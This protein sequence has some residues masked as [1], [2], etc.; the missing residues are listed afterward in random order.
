LY[1]AEYSSTSHFVGI[2]DIKKAILLEG[3][4][5]ASIAID[6][7]FT[8]YHGGIYRSSLKPPIEAGNHAVEIIGWGK[9]NNEEYWIILNQYGRF[10]GENGRIRIKM[11]TNE[12]LIESF[13]YGALPVLDGHLNESSA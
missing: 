8:I 1:R 5:S 11:G 9:E 6:R 13:V 2:E 3:P 4:V 7:W 10:W 12:G